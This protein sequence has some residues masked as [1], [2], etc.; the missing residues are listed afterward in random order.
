MPVYYVLIGAPGSGKSVYAKRL[1]CRIVSPDTIRDN[2]RI[3]VKQ[4][5][6]IARKEIEEALRA[7]I[8]VAMDATNTTREN[9]ILSINVGKP[10]ADKVIGIWLDTPYEV[11]VS[12]HLKRIN[13]MTM[14][15]ERYTDEVGGVPYEEIIRKYC[16]Q[17]ADIPDVSEGFDKLVRIKP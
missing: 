2:Q 12:R 15:S 17:L 10:Y 14:I 9:R 3:G 5:Y 16:L 4:S 6:T 1:N 13:G 7:G 11:C 8:D